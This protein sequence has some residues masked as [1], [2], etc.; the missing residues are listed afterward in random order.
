MRHV[1][2]YNAVLWN[3]YEC[4]RTHK[5][6]WQ[7]VS[8]PN[9]DAAAKA[10][11]LDL[12]QRVG[13]AV[14]ARRKALKMT[15]QR[16][17]ER[18]A[19]LGYPITRVAISKIESN[20]RA[21]KLDVAELIVLAK[22]LEMPPILLLYPGFPDGYDATV[23]KRS[24]PGEPYTVDFAGDVETLPGKSDS[25]REAVLWFSG[26][27]PS[28]WIPGDK[29]LDEVERSVGATLVQ[30]DALAVEEED[31]LRA[32]RREVERDSLSPE[33]AERVRREIKHIE[34]VVARLRQSVAGDQAELWGIALEREERARRDLRARGLRVD[35]DA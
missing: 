19:E 27:L 20:K 35:S 26:R 7:N 32:G 9:I 4:A 31:R 2:R 6:V 24:G 15:A 18:T 1:P 25:S 8:M 16:L 34:A 12:A 23:D 21:G 10:W 17:A 13:E 30:T 11:E 22:G 33:D 29:R 14:Q 5:H 3:I 28:M